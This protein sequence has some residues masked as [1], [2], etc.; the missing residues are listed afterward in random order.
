MKRS[1]LMCLLAGKNEE[2]SIIKISKG[3][4]VTTKSNETVPSPNYSVDNYCSKFGHY[5]KVNC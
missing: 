4:F 1:R 5:G 3:K 2:L